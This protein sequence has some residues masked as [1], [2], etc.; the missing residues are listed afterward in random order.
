MC[1]DL[2]SNYLVAHRQC[3]RRLVYPWFELTLVSIS[4]FTAVVIALLLTTRR[5]LKSDLAMV[6]KGNEDEKYP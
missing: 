5:A 6:L 2:F 3:S 4:V 1:L